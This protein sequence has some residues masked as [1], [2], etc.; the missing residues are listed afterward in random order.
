MKHFLLVLVFGVLLYGF[1][2]LSSPLSR[3]IGSRLLER[4]GLR[5][6]VFFLFLLSLLALAYYLPSLRLL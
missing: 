5:L 1:W 6:L 3:K 4:H 2:Y